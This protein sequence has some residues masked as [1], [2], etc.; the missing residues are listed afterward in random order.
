MS[1][2]FFNQ[3]FESI[4]VHFKLQNKKCL[5]SLKNLIS[6]TNLLQLKIII[7]GIPLSNKLKSGHENLLVGIFLIFRHIFKT[8]ITQL[9]HVFIKILE[10]PV[11]ISIL[12]L[13]SNFTIRIMFEFVL[14]FI[15]EE[16]IGKV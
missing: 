4:L 5:G 7:L 15:W 1:P 9:E 2:H 3:S 12:N 16:K 11:L 8:A 6:E 14:F 10:N 13:L